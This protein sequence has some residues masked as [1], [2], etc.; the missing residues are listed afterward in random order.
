MKKIST[1]LVLLTLS[2]QLFA[3]DFRKDL[4]AS[5]EKR[6][7]NHY[8]VQAGDLLEIDNSY[9]RVHVNTWDKN[10]VEVE[11]KITTKARTEEKAEEMLDRINIDILSNEHG[12]HK[13]AYTTD[14]GKSLGINLN[15]NTEMTIDY[16]VYAPKK[17]PLLITNKFGDVYIDDIEGKLEVEVGYGALTTR[18]ITGQNAKVKVTFGSASISSIE[19]GEV[20]ASYSKL[21]ID[22][23][24]N[25]QVKNSFGK[26]N[27]DQVQT[28]DIYQKYG[29]LNI[30]T[31][32][33]IIGEVG[34]SGMDIDKLTKCAD[35]T[36]RYCSRAKIR[37]IG[38]GVTLADIE[39]YFSTLY[40]GFEP[41]INMKIDGEC[42][43]GELKNDLPSSV[44][45]IESNRNT[46]HSNTKFYNG[47]IGNGSNK[48]IL[49]FHYGNVHLRD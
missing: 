16:T 13:I 15:I 7:K 27:I 8:T 11:V 14:I 44:L 2:L 36:L 46:E 48:L 38:T 25:I 1:L 6:I 37:S 47:K 31:V 23:A 3:R 12:R 18:E 33:K 28:L 49:N 24:S 41:G 30:G 34:F 40:C 22:K 5:R 19:T 20:E 32:G 39:G 45:E 21:S 29:D 17:N 42:S 43:F 10:E 4:H 9:G 35:L 26:T